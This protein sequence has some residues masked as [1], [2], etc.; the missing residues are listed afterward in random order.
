MTNCKQPDARRQSSWRTFAHLL[1]FGFLL[2]LVILLVRGTPVST[3]NARRVVFTEADV[4]QVRARY[5][6]V[7]KR[8]PTAIELRGVFEQYVRE[9]IFYRQ[10]LAL[11]LDRADPTVRMAIVRKVMMLGLAQAES[12]ELT[13]EDVQAY[14]A[15]RKEHYR[16]PTTV[17]LMQVYI[18]KDRHGNNVYTYTAQLLDSFSRNEPRPEKLASLGDPFRLGNVYND[19]FEQDLDRTFGENFGASVLALTPG[20]WDGPI[21]SNYGLHLVKVIQ[22]T[23]SRI[24]DWTEIRQRIIKDMRYDARKAAEDQFYAEIAPLY[25]VVYD[26]AAAAALEEG[27]P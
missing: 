4:E 27:N 11:N 20:R 25:H 8:S 15:L 2:A 21:E 17:S 16:T 19:M 24:P 23:E 7:W 10:G 12:A 13:D 9:E 1:A 22:H 3:E 26:N 18:S 5:I 6:R 14:F